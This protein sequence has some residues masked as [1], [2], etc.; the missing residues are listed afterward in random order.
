VPGV[1]S[2]PLD[3]PYSRDF[4]AFYDEFVDSIPDEA[5]F[6]LILRR[7]PDGQPLA[8][9]LASFCG[10]V[11]AAVPIYER[12]RSRFQPIRD[13]VAPRPYADSQRLYD[14]IS[15][16]GLRNYWKT[17]A[18]G[19]LVAGAI[20]ATADVFEGAPS[21][22]SQVQLEHL[23][24]AM[25]RTPAGTNALRF[26]DAKFDL[27]VNAKWTDPA[28][29]G[30]N[31]RWAREGYAALEPF[32]R[33]GAYPNYLFQE[34]GERVRQAYGEQSFRRLVA[35]KDHF[36]PTNFFRLNQNI[37]PGVRA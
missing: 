35:L 15:P 5:S 11:D 34:S 19:P 37:Q 29:D 7:T 10:P 33:A 28:Q 8:T 27:L 31:V 2:G 13:G 32:T 17:N 1:V 16:W 20:A 23:H 36:D 12:L 22:L 4:L 24:G 18:M 9:V 14:Q 6:D 26:G 25:H 3:F 30:E 21:A